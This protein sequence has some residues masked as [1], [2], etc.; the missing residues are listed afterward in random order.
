MESENLS[1]N[2]REAKLSNIIERQKKILIVDDEQFNRMAVGVIL[3]SIGLPNYQDKCVYAINGQVALDIITNDIE[4]NS[5][6]YCSFD[7]I[8][9]DC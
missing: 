1:I 8:L 5:K 3:N 2:E 4:Q 7:L 6:Y 9:M